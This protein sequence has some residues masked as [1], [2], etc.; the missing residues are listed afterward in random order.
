M[1]I[2]AEEGTEPDL[3][4]TAPEILEG[5]QPNPKSVV[6]SLGVLLYY[7]CT[8]KVPFSDANKYALLEKMESGKYDPISECKPIIT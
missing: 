4:F 7:L 5:E 2:Q 3:S 1:L 8:F 6:W